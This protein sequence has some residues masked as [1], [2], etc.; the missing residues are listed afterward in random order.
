MTQARFIQIDPAISDYYNCTCRC[1]RKSF[2]CGYD[3]LT[4]TDFSH[5]KLWFVERLSKLTQAFAIDVC[6][7]AIMSNHAHYVL[8]INHNQAENWT[9][10]EVISR[11]HSLFKGTL[12]SR[13]FLAGKH[14]MTPASDY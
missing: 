11:W 3:K 7:Y 8:H 4:E 14:W 10:E 5:R 13:Q 9:D 6:S 1:V 12:Q 2:L